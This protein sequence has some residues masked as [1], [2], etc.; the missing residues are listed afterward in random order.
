M[1]EPDDTTKLDTAAFAER[2]R[3]RRGEPPKPHPY[4]A[5]Q[6][7]YLGMDVGRDSA[8]AAAPVAKAAPRSDSDF[9]V[10]IGH[11]L[12]IIDLCG[13]H[14]VT[15]INHLTASFGLTDPGDTRLHV[16]AR[17]ERL[18]RTTASG[19]SFDIKSTIGA[20]SVEDLGYLCIALGD[21]DMNMGVAERKVRAL[22]AF[23]KIK[24]DKQK[25]STHAVRIGTP[26][27]P[28]DLDSNTP[29]HQLNRALVVLGMDEH[30]MRGLPTNAVLQRIF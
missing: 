9:D 23:E 7:R 4:E 17:L 28:L 6:E 29:R 25:Q 27:G 15:A 22:R 30:A 10:L 18:A 19:G 3:A 24:K 1:S 2:M 13:E 20:L 26:D 14:V 16:K 5:Q 12:A 8:M 11:F 21:F